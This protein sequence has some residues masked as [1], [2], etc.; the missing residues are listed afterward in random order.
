M[1]RAATVERAGQTNY[2]GGFI[3]LCAG[4]SR[5]FM[6]VCIYIYIYTERERDVFVSMYQFVDL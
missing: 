5:V 4:R 1:A 2:P 6:C 3:V